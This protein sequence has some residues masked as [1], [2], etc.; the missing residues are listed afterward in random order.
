MDDTDRAEAVL[1]L[2]AARKELAEAEDSYLEAR[3]RFRDHMKIYFGK[4]DHHEADM[5]FY[6]KEN[7]R[8][9][10]FAAQD[11]INHFKKKLPEE[12]GS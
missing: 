1:N 4:R 9:K 11:K 5:A 6:Q 8:A 12:S 7:F 10:I 3:G 2:I